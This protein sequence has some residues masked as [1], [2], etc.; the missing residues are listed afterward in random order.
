MNSNSTHA[1]STPPRYSQIIV[2]LVLV[3]LCSIWLLIIQFD[4]PWKPADPTATTTVVV[5]S[6]PPAGLR[7]TRQSLATRN[8]AVQLTTTATYSE[9]YPAPLDTPVPLTPTPE[10]LSPQPTATTEPITTAIVLLTR[11][12]VM[13][14]AEPAGQ[15]ALFK[16]PSNE[17]AITLGRSAD[18]LWYF[19]EWEEER[20]WLPAGQ[21]TLL[22]P[23]T[24][25][26][27]PIIEG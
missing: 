16:I 12:E 15:T 3:S 10:S 17:L 25:D 9:S 13:L 8:T 21:T 5:E 23:A 19:V 2:G 1:S 7:Q 20:G 11:M 14:Y 6:I 26:L 22:Y 18:G 27:L 4:A 24:P